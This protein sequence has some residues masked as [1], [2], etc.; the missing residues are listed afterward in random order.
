MSSVERRDPGANK[1]R[2]DPEP[3]S[4]V[5][6]ESPC[7]NLDTNGWRILDSSRLSCCKAFA[8]CLVIRKST[9]SGRPQKLTGSM[10]SEAIA[11]SSNAERQPKR[12]ISTAA[13][14]P[15]KVPPSE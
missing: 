1:R 3:W 14:A 4:P 11:P 13:I 15:P 7:G 12:S 5:T 10:H 8:G 9:D 2:S 6:G